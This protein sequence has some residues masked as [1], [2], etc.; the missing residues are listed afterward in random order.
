MVDSVSLNNSDL[1]PPSEEGVFKKSPS[2]R[3]R[4]KKQKSQNE[5]HHRHSYEPIPHHLHPYAYGA[6]PSPMMP[7]YGP[8]PYRCSCEARAVQGMFPVMGGYFYP[9][10]PQ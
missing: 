8:A 10:P 4:S 6:G 3:V 9:A 5:R 2:K 1:K 7:G